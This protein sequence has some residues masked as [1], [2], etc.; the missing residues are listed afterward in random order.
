MPKTTKEKIMERLKKSKCIRGI[1]VIVVVILLII[2]AYK[3]ISAVFDEKENIKIP[4]ETQ[5]NK[6]CE[7]INAKGYGYTENLKEEKIYIL[8]KIEY[9]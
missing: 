3:T 2:L 7:K 8:C 4:N 6:I 9:K 1:L 5:I